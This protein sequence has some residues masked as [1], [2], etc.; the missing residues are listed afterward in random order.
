[1]RVTERMRYDQA[2]RDTGRAREAAESAIARAS[3]GVRVARAKDDPGAAGL[4]ALDRA[5]S[6][7]LEA[8]A[9]T[10]ARASDELSAVDGALDTVNNAIT[11]ARELAVQLSN[12][13]YSAG[14]RAGAAGEVRGLL[15]TAVG[16]LN[17]QVGGRYVLAGNLDGTAPF[18]AAGAYSGDAAV[19]QL[20]IAP[21]V[22]QGA[23][24]RADVAVKGAGG[25][26][27]VLQAL[28]DLATALASNDA[29]Q[30]RAAL[31]PLAQGTAQL[32][33]ARAEV[34][35]AMATL[36]AAVV[37]SRAGRDEATAAASRLADAD[38]IVAATELSRTQAALDAS[39]TA[40]A[41]GFQLSL[42]DKLG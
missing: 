5:R 41:K 2:T 14:E 40:V 8:I 36:D 29:T 13:T 19:R 9:S 3:T 31:D 28:A 25:G 12:S 37:A 32:S 30:I 27:D 15:A 11:R 39:L 26:V 38:P 24:V 35:T 34:G 4:V 18:D 7:R 22:L 16:A 42:L 10:A 23:S 1:M 6:E 21:G 17:A 20:E 33:R